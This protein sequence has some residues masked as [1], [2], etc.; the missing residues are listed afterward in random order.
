MGTTSDLT[1]EK[2]KLRVLLAKLGLD[3]HWRGA[4]VVATALKNAGMEVIYIGNQSPEA[5]AEIALQ[6]DVD[7]VGLSTLSGNYFPLG[8]RA[9]ECL[10]E[11]GL[12]AVPV[13][14]GGIVAERDL[15][16]LYQAG[17]TKVFGPGTRTGE[18][19]NYINT[20]LRRVCETRTTE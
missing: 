16:E 6:E 14:M 10:R 3:S 15:P 18:I 1:V 11:K 8:T 12:G 20:N 9:V 7:V 4:L 2:R 5:I 17:I 19:I 13:I